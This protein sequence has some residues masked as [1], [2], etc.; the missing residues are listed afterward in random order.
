M[1][2]RA[3]N[4]QIYARRRHAQNFMYEKNQALT[5]PVSFT[6]FYLVSDMFVKISDSMPSGLTGD[7]PFSMYVK[8]FKRQ[9]ILTP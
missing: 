7:Y 9:A 1:Y 8:L 3:S 4:F 6:L 2:Q 5:K